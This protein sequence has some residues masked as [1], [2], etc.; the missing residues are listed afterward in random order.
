MTKNVIVSKTVKIHLHVHAMSDVFKFDETDAVL[1]ID[2]SNAFN[3][4]NR[5]VALH[6]M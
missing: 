3:Q 1:L 4:M 2:A 5:M 6:N